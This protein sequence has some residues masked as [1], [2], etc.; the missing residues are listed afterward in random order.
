MNDGMK[1]IELLIDRYIQM[2]VNRGDSY[3]EIEAFVDRTIES[4]IKHF[5]LGGEYELN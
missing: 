5:R 2:C 4:A 1:A 3:Q